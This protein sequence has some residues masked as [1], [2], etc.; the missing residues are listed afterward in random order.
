MK[1]SQQLQQCLWLISTIYSAG[2]ITFDELNER[3]KA[4]ELSGGLDFSRTTFNRIR[5]AVQSM[6]GIIIECQIKGGYRYYI[7]NQEDLACKHRI[8]ELCE[9]CPC[10][11]KEQDVFLCLSQNCIYIKL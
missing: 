10:R 7:Y 6:F 1:L 2:S 4:S 5:D 9:K 11:N 8:S 3:W